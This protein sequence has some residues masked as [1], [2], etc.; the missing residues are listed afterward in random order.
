MQLPD[1]YEALHQRAVES[2]DSE[3]LGPSVEQFQRL[4]ERLLSLSPQVR[5]RRPDLQE[6]LEDSALRWVTMLRWDGQSEEALALARRLRDALPAAKLFWDVE[7]ALDLIDLGNV[8][9]GLDQLRALMMQMPEARNAIR[10]L[11]AKELLHAGFDDEAQ[12]VGLGALR[13]AS[14]D[15]ELAEAVLFLVELETERNQPHAM[16]ASVERVA[17]RLD[18]GFINPLY[19]RLS[20]LGHMEQIET[21][22]A[23]EKNGFVR[24]LFQGEVARS[25]GDEARASELWQSV[26]DEGEKV[27]SQADAYAWL[28]AK[29]LLGHGLDVLH[30]ATMQYQSTLNESSALL[31]LVATLAQ[32]ERLDDAKLILKRA[33]RMTRTLRPKWQTF[34]RS[35]WLRLLRYPMPD[36]A[37]EALRPYFRTEEA[38]AAPGTEVAPTT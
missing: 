9:R 33:L 15:G 38:E 5:Q 14:D 28:A 22:L 35:Y 24:R 21:L 6:I 23:E 16:I 1:S 37:R 4:T 29:L 19:E 36:E 18:Q 27:K 7:E 32:A 34:P 3:N 11:L 17:K 20:A 31:I 25:K 26:A 8:S 30:P 2:V 13:A 12:T 10:L